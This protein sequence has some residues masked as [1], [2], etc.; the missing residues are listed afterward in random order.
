MSGQ[1]P[2]RK[3]FLT[4]TA[5]AAGVAGA[6]TLGPA[7]PAHG[8]RPVRRAVCR[9]S[10]LSRGERG[11]GITHSRAPRLGYLHRVSDRAPGP[12]GPSRTLVIVWV[13]AVVVL[14]VATRLFALPLLQ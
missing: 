4:G 3:E 6:A 9:S 1:N 12:K 13:A 5:A 14:Y 2:T 11:Q 7:R 8:S 10:R